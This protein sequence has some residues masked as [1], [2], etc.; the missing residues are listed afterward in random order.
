MANRVARGTLFA[1]LSNRTGALS[2][3]AAV[4]GY[5]REWSHW[6]NWL[7]FEIWAAF[8]DRRVIL[9]VASDA[10]GIRQYQP[11]P[12]LTTVDASSTKVHERI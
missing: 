10:D 6:S 5:L 12:D 1:F 9:S 4:G 8:A 11:W 3:I 7:R 2:R